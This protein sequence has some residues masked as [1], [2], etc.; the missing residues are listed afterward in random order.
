VFN[1]DTCRFIIWGY[2]KIYHT[3]THIHE[4]FYRTLQHM[5]KQVAWLDNPNGVDFSNTYIISE[6]D[7]SKSLPIRDDCFLCYSWS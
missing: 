4:G 7:A 3:H 1:L 6:H 2:K 5:G